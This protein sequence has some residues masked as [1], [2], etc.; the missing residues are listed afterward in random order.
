MGNQLMA[1]RSPRL[2]IDGIG[3]DGGHFHCFLV[4]TETLLT[5]SPMGQT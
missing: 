4:N 3:P 5:Q 2:K 1:E